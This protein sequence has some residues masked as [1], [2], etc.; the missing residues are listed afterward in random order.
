[1]SKLTLIQNDDGLEFHIDEETN[2]A[3]AS[4]EVYSKIL[5]VQ[6]DLDV[7][8]EIAREHNIEC[9]WLDIGF[10]PVAVFPSSFLFF[11]ALELCP[12][13]VSYATMGFVPS[14][15]QYWLSGTPQ[16]SQPLQSSKSHVYLIEC[17]VTGV[18]KV[19]MSRNPISRLASIQGSYPYLLKIRA[20]SLSSNARAKERK[21]HSKLKAFKLSGE[22][23]SKDGF[24][25]AIELI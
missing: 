21:I 15:K 18:F 25:E 9:L 4:I 11:L 17:S 12:E 22:W 10:N 5:E 14:A 2:I 6:N 8:C 3:Y 1:M 19:G 20:C 13:K 16:K 23:F 7:F 24:S